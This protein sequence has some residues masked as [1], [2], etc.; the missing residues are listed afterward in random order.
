MKVYKRVI[1][2]MMGVLWL[3]LSPVI[4]QAD[5]PSPPAQTPPATRP[6]EES[7]SIR[8]ASAVLDFTR[9]NNAGLS[10]VSD[11]DLLPKPG[12]SGQLAP[13]NPIIVAEHDGT[14]FKVTTNSTQMIGPNGRASAI[15]PASSSQILAEDF[16]GSVGPPWVN[17]DNNEAT[18]GLY[19]WA[20]EPCFS[21]TGFPLGSFGTSSMWVA[22]T[23]DTDLNPCSGGKY[24]DNLDAWLVYGPFSLADANSAF[25][26]FYFW[27]DNGGDNDDFLF[28]GVSLNADPFTSATFHGEMVS[29][30]HN[31]GPFINSSS[32]GHNF[33]SLDLTQVPTLGDVTGQDQ[34]WL[35]FRF[36][37]DGDGATGQGAFIDSVSVRKNSGLKQEIIVEDFDPDVFPTGYVSWLGDDNNE[38]TG[39]EARWGSADCLPRSLSMSM[40]AARDGANGLDPCAGSVN[41]PPNMDSWLIYGPFSLEN[42]SE[43]WVDFYFRNDSEPGGDFITWFASTNGTNY[44]GFG[45]SSTFTSGPHNNGYNRMQLDLSN[46]PILGD[47]RDQPTVW[48]AFIFNSDG[49]ATVG[50]GVFID[51]VSVVMIDQ[52]IDQGLNT[53]VFLP[54]L[55]RSEPVPVGGLMFVNDTGHPVII[56]LIGYGTRTFPAT[57]GP[58]TWDNIPA[59]VYDWLA[60]GTCPAGAGQV[61]SLPPSLREK[62]TILAGKLDNV[63]NKENDGK[64]DCSG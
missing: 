10:L 53:N 22:G 21:A 63:I 52:G 56:Q 55:I 11:R 41:Y 39:G 43:A 59:G 47:L 36:F 20:K 31:D 46:V 1:W 57:M 13:P 33:V 51:D 7:I 5:P 35:G 61:G 9:A 32:G 24:P 17:Y 28:W 3:G 42:A 25:L 12:I 37:S 60:S 6:D 29:G 62:V 26:D 58:Q 40:W 19:S 34:V 14:T 48:L 45:I 38:S 64:F 18:G 23:G 2:L 49:N 16:E 8:P 44:H 50:E 4:S 15:G 27:L 30:V 54:L